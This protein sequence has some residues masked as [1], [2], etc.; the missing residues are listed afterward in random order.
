MAW[1]KPHEMSDTLS[2]MRVSFRKDWSPNTFGVGDLC[3][4]RQSELFAPGEVYTWSVG[5]V[6]SEDGGLNPNHNPSHNPTPHHNLYH[7]PNPSPN[8]IPTH[9]LVITD[10]PSRCAPTH[11][12]ITPLTSSITPTPVQPIT[13][14]PTTGPSANAESPTPLPVPSLSQDHL[15]HHQ[16]HTSSSSSA[17]VISNYNNNNKSIIPTPTTTPNSQPCQGLRLGLGFVEP[18]NVNSSEKKEEEK[19]LG[20]E[21]GMMGSS[22]S[23]PSSFSSL[24]ESFEEQPLLTH[25]RTHT[26]RRAPRRSCA[27]SRGAHQRQ[28]MSDLANTERINR[29]DMTIRKGLKADLKRRMAFFV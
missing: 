24:R 4:I 6:V 23:S 19:G 20:L 9:P 13:T 16:Q 14:H 22:S 7:G 25:T 5:C 1:L 27:I 21:K 18:V 11:A 28:K 17:P 3:P 15:H 29:G 12:S 10:S 26:P 2:G 8:H